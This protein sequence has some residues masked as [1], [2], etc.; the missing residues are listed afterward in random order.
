VIK[1]I[2]DA[3]A[4]TR[5]ARRLT[6]TVI[7]SAA[8]GIMMVAL[9]GSAEAQSTTTLVNVSTQL[10]L[11]S[12]TNGDVYTLPCNGGNFQHWQLYP[13]GSNSY[14]IIDVSTQ[15]CLDSNTSGNLYTLPCNGGN[16]QVWMMSGGSSPNSFQDLSTGMCLDS[17][18]SGNAYTQACNGG[19]FQ[20]W[21]NS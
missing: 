16:F 18:A 5:R 3:S 9:P 15:R 12:N 21:Q 8:A 13:A 6:A 11:D 14:H 7:A 2:G 20:E 19:N 1:P 10:C 17:N 4:G